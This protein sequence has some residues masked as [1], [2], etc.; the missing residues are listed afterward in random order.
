[1]TAKQV[2]RPTP[3]TRASATVRQVNRRV[4]KTAAV[5][6]A[7][8]KLFALIA[9]MRPVSGPRLYSHT[10]A[11]LEVLGITTATKASA[12]R[13]Q[14]LIGPRAFSYHTKVTHNLEVAG[15][16]VKLSSTGDEFFQ[17]REEEGKAP[18][19]LIDAFVTVFRTGKPSKTAEVKAHHISA[20]PI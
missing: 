1:M 12:P 6:T 4:S 18:R 11:A 17:A 10:I 9:S 20:D 19:D 5:T 2:T 7:P 15:E 3:A 16:T 14:A 8:A 13:L